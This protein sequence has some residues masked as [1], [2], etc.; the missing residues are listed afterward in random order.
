MLSVPSEPSTESNEVQVMLLQVPDKDVT[1][2]LIRRRTTDRLRARS[3]GCGTAEYSFLGRAK[4]D[5]CL[6]CGRWWFAQETPV[7]LRWVRRYCESG[8]PPQV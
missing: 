7:A 3:F 1:S 8:S 6:S 5:G 4:L 2:D